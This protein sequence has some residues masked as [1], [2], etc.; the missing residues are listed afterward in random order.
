MGVVTETVSE[1]V[2][3]IGNQVPRNLNDWVPSVS[4][5]QTGGLRETAIIMAEI[6]YWGNPDDGV[7]ARTLLSVVD[8]EPGGRYGIVFRTTCAR[9]YSA[10]ELRFRRRL[11]AALVEEAKRQGFVYM[12]IPAD[13]TKP[14]L[15]IGGNR[16]DVFPIYQDYGIHPVE[17][18]LG[19]MYRLDLVEPGTVPKN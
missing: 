5:R 4:T 3:G 16:D 12:L 11:L 13:F 10:F 8:G 6:H 14:K 2:P 9:D 7:V 19:M 15:S 18:R 17:S 1:T